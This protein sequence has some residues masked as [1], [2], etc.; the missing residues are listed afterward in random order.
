M[1]NALLAIVS[2]VIGLLAWAALDDITTGRQPTFVLEWM[3]VGVA[4]L[5]VVLLVILWRRSRGRAR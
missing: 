3:M 4:A 2:L 5:W 1:R